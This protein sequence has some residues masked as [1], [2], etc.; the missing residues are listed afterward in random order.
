[1]WTSLSLGE[2]TRVG[3]LKPLRSQKQYK[4]SFRF[5]KVSS[6][7]GWRKELGFKS[8]STSPLG[9]EWYS[10]EFR[11]EQVSACLVLPAAWEEWETGAQAKEPLDVTAIQQ[12]WTPV[13][14]RA[15]DIQ[16]R[17]SWGHN[18]RHSWW[19]APRAAL[20]SLV[21]GIGK[22]ALERLPCSSSAWAPRSPGLKRCSY[23][24]VGPG[25]RSAARNC[26]V[27]YFG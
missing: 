14:Q 9:C 26:S 8:C 19:Q 25:A 3:C 5:Y 17:H 27:S 23:G 2:G 20:A 16:T 7:G 6:H 4:I 12:K 18:W 11:E 10:W 15:G 22:P 21:E 1:M 13:S 24:R